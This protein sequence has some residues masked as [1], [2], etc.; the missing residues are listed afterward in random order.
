MCKNIRLSVKIAGG[1]LCVLILSSLVA[2]FGYRGLSNVTERMAIGDDVNE[3]VKIMLEIR[4]HEKNFIIRG[5]QEYADQVMNLL[6]EMKNQIRASK[7][8]FRVSSEKKRIDEIMEQSGLY[9]AAFRE[10]ADIKNRN[11]DLEQLEKLDANMV[12]SA[13]SVLDICYKTRD[14]QKSLMR[15]QISDSKKFMGIGSLCVFA[16]GILFAFFLTREITRPIIRVVQGLTGSSDEVSAA[17]GQVSS[18]GIMLAEG[19][20]EQAAAAEET[21][22]SLAEIS[23]MIC[24]NSENAVRADNVMKEVIDIIKKADRSLSELKS[25]MGETISASDQ[26]FHIVKTIDEIAFQTNLLA[27]NAAVEA[28]RAGESGAGFAVVAG[29]VRNLA[30]RASEAARTTSELIEK[31]V[32]QIKTGFHLLSGAVDAFSSVAE[33]S[34]HAGK[35]VG[36]IAEASREQSRGIEQLQKAVSDMEKVI[37]QNASTAEE[38]AAASEELNAQAQEMK[39]FTHALS[40]MIRGASN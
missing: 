12:A 39:G 16:A 34:A 22:A 21:A 33:H 5:K 14:D 4:R 37:H 25:S 30:L 6:G 26:T 38:S 27:L 7:E 19:A 10:Y 8:K 40:A 36:E 29:E 28:A 31:T 18:A 35:I 20:S 32:Q 3:I 11:P 23:A 24:Q 2:W 9:E 13:R 1:F 15:S 17:S